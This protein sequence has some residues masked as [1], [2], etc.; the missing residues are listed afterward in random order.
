MN[1]LDLMNSI[2]KRVPVLRR[3]GLSVA[4]D[5]PSGGDAEALAFCIAR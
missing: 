3:R 4:R 1:S 5:R 2:E